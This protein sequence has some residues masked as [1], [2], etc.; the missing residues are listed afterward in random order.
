LIEFRRVSKVYAS[1]STALRH[2]SFKINDG[3]FVFIIGRS[4]AGKSTLIKLL[5]CEERPTSGQVMIDQIDVARIRRGLIPYLRRNIGMVFQDFRLIYTKTVFENVAFAMEIVGSSPRLIRRRVPIVLSIVGLRDKANARPGELSG[6]EQ[7]RVAIARAMVNNPRLILADEPTGNLDPTNSEAVMALLEEINRSGTTV[8]ICTH[9][10]A[11]VDRMKK[12]VVEI[13]DGSMI[14]DDCSGSY[15]S[16]NA[17]CAVPAARTAA[18]RGRHHRNDVFSVKAA[19]SAGL[20]AD[21][22]NEPD[23]EPAPEDLA[24]PAAPVSFRLPRKAAPG[25]ASRISR[26][27]G[28]G[29]SGESGISAG[30]GADAANP[31][32]P[33]GSGANP[34]GSTWVKPAPKPTKPEELP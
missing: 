32:K 13:D 1:G 29:H 31:L 12:R 3:E 9:D 27:P 25:P 20:L 18:V 8:I 5:T 2:V 22:Q 23:R 24:D 7:Q 11:L 10:H 4:G 21:E 30:P 33:A 26:T 16:D 19:K 28:P 15:V 17:A 14:R 6:G 34:P